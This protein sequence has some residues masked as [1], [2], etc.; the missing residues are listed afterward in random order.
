[1]N[2]NLLKMNKEKGIKLYYKKY[3]FN[4]HNPCLGTHKTINTYIIK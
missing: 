2:N 4:Y 3:Y 1:M